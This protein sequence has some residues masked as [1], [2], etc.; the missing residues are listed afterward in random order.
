MKISKCFLCDKEAIY[1]DVVLNNS[2][3][4]IADVCQ[5]HFSVEFVS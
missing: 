2:E 5:D 1:Y 4:I 3:Y